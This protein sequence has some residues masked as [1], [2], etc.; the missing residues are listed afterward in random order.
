MGKRPAWRREWSVTALL[1]A[2][3]AVVGAVNHAFLR[4]ANLRDMLIDDVP[5]VIV[6]CGMTL[7]IV[8]GE[9]DISVGSLMGLLAT[10]LGE[11][12]SPSHAGLPVAAAIAA[13]LLLGAGVGLINGLL[14]TF[15]RM[16]SIIVTLAMLT[17]LQGI[18]LILMNGAWITDMPA[19]L[20]Y[21]GVGRMFG[22][23][24]SLWTAAAVVA[25]F[26]LLASRTPLGR[27]IWAVGSNPEAAR[28]AG[29]SARNMK[30][31][32]FIMTGLLTA[33][34]TIV[35]VPRLGVIEA[36]VGQG[37]ELLVVTCVVVGGTS[38]SGGRG[39]VL[40]SVLAALLLGAVGNMLIFLH[41]G[42]SATYW[43]RAIQGVFILAAV[44]ADHLARRRPRLQT[45]MQASRE[46]QA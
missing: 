3:M 8:T 31:F 27:R 39:T 35:S 25:L 44:L 32:A 20:R 45:R 37:F 4:P 30:L 13:V 26:M 14:V 38:I 7:V 15:A 22:V 18:G 29:L 46:A 41:L 43:E 1:F 28:L 12:T 21:F 36:G 11:L 10:V 5:T 42:L 34:A 23:P 19:G 9:I 33:V 24:I 17:I 16:P 40:G 2:T 6:A